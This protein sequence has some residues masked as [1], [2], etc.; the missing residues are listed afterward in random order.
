[1]R[2]YD[3]CVIIGINRGNVDALVSTMK[4][5]SYPEIS[6]KYPIIITEAASY[7]SEA[8]SSVIVAGDD[9]AYISTVNAIRYKDTKTFSEYTFMTV[10]EFVNRHK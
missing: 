6:S 9:H 10:T 3:K 7:S 5:N 1:M 8:R 4:A 2:K